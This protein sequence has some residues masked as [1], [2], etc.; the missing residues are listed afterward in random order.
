M[1]EQQYSRSEVDEEMEEVEKMPFEKLNYREQKTVG[2]RFEEFLK[3]GSLYQKH[4][5]EVLP[6]QLSQIRPEVLHLFCSTC[7]RENPFRTPASP[8]RIARA[9]PEA[10]IG[11]PGR[12]FHTHIETAHQKELKSR[13]YVIGLE[14]TGCSYEQVTY[15]IEFDT[16]RKR[17]R[18]VGQIPEPSITVSRDLAEALGE[19]TDLYKKAKICLNQSYGVAACA[20]LRRVLENRITPLL[21]IIRSI[22]VEEGAGE[23][24]LNRLDELIGGTVAKDKIGLAGEVLPSSLKVE[25]DNALYLL[26]DELSFGIHSGDEDECV[27]IAAGALSS[28][29]YMLVE[30]GTGHRKREAKKDF[31]ENI[32]RA[33][34]SKTK[35]ARE[36]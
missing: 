29:D 24:E 36:R 25:G 17:V 32:K 11:Y 19:D 16:T 31:Q 33:R 23:D 3:G 18:K 10:D 4:R 2:E 5:F 26:Y 9:Q 27:E 21:E 22:R 28:L 8:T 20:C 35:R 6:D 1:S 13:V 15:W 12:G 14:C 7:E 34:Q 30:L